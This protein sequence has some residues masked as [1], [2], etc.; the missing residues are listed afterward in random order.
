MNRIL[1]ATDGSSG[2]REA[3]E[4]ALEL[5]S[6]TGAH[7]SIVYVRQGPHA[8][9]G[10]PYFE[11]TLA[12]ELQAAHAVLE[13]AAARAATI[14][15]EIEPEIVDGDPAGEIVRLARMRNADLI[16]VGS[17]ALGAFAATLLG[18]VSR[19]VVDHADRPVLVVTHRASERRVA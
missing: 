5:A 1:V 3:V 16:V 15:V 14:G 2:G 11:R 8:M 19:T 6:A 18:S 12:A 10:D 7:V 17:R 13:E 9:F 4:R